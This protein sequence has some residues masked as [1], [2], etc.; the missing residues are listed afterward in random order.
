MKKRSL[1]TEFR[2]NVRIPVNTL[3]V[4]SV[5]LTSLLEFIRQNPLFSIYSEDELT[6]LLKTAELKSVSAGELIFDRGDPGDMFY[7]VYSGRIR[8]LLSVTMCLFPRLPLLCLCFWRPIPLCR[9]RVLRKPGSSLPP[10]EL[11][12]DWYSF[13]AGSGGGLMPGQR[14]LLYQHHCS[15]RLC[16]RW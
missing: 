1:Q 4:N 8:I 16:L 11:E 10:W 14:L 7:I 9:C 5:T 13:Y 3:S 6:D 12:L 2:C 15:W